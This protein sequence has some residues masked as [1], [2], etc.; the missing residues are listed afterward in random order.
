[1]ADLQYWRI[2][3]PEIGESQHVTM[4]ATGD[5]H[6]DIDNL[7]YHLNQDLANGGYYLPALT[8]FEKWES[9]TDLGGPSDDGKDRFRKHRLMLTVKGGIW[10]HYGY[11][12]YIHRLGA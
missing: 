2:V 10:T 5:D 6:D 7:Q 1:M 12:D 3:D 4:L 8:V 11:Q 9:S